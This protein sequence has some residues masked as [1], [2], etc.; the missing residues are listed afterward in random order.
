MKKVMTDLRYIINSQNIDISKLLKM[1]G[2]KETEEL[3]EA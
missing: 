1:I 3:N 2:L